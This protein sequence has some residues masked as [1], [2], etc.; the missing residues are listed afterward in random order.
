MCRPADDSDGAA[1]GSPGRSRAGQYQCGSCFL[2]RCSP[3][4]Q[5][6]V[7]CRQVPQRRRAICAGSLCGGDGNL[8]NEQ[9]RGLL[10]V[11]RPGSDIRRSSRI[12]GVLSETN[13][14]RYGDGLVAGMPLTG[15]RR[16]AVHRRLHAPFPVCQCQPHAARTVL[17]PAEQAG[18]S[19]KRTL[20]RMSSSC[21][22]DSSRAALD[23]DVILYG[24]V[25]V[26]RRSEQAFDRRPHDCA[27]DLSCFF[28][29]AP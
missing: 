28:R 23:E 27:V 7:H 21:P 24:T 3:H 20:Q 5:R 12:V 17:A 29:R 11:V 22:Q 15:Q 19:G 2:R 26:L 8:N 18:R 16:L 9:G 4:E 13:A 1:A 14:Q 25:S 10:L 6:R